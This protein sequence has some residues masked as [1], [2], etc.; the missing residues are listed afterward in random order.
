MKLLILFV[1]GAWPLVVVA[2]GPLLGLVVVVG[3]QTA[4]EKVIGDHVIGR[5]LAGVLLLGFAWLY[6]T[7]ALEGVESGFRES[8]YGFWAVVMQFTVRY[9]TPILF[10]GP[11]AL[12]GSGATAVKE[13]PSRAAATVPPRTLPPGFV[14]PSRGRKADGPG[15]LAWIALFALATLAIVLVV[16][17]ELGESPGVGTSDLVD[18]QAAKP[19][20]ARAASAKTPSSTPTLAADD[21]GVGSDPAWSSS[22]AKEAAWHKALKLA[23][24]Q[25]ALR[26]THLLAAKNGLVFEL[27][28]A[29]PPESVSLV[30]RVNRLRRLV[31]KNRAA[32]AHPPVVGLRHPA[33]GRVAY[34]VLGERKHRTY[35]GERGVLRQSRLDYRL[36]QSSVV[37]TIRA[38]VYIGEVKCSGYLVWRSDA[39]PPKVTIACAGKSGYNDFGGLTYPFEATKT[40]RLKKRQRKAKYSIRVKKVMGHKAEGSA[41]VF[42]DGKPEPTFSL[43]AEKQAR[44]WL[45]MLDKIQRKIGLRYRSPSGAL[46]NA[47]FGKLRYYR[48]AELEFEA[49]SAWTPKRAKSRA[50]KA[51]RLLTKHYRKHH[52][53]KKPVVLVY[54]GGKLLATAKRK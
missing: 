52:R 17:R 48:L 35:H 20:P 24:P 43:Y 32:A 18:S 14:S 19:S 39:P 26:R 23:E 46:R 31:D 49:K 41:N 50:R 6:Y 47:E 7:T 2:A 38:G 4:I 5:V 45:S 12:C 34:S 37:T 28:G 9:V 53:G 10:L 22:G 16:A 42:I 25:V 29:D 40:I 36:D 1:L 54:W 33:T 13:A 51:L 15:W 3:A 30:Q 11:L 27:E 21:S 44:A 8:D